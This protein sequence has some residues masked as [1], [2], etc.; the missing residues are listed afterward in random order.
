MPRN[1]TLLLFMLF[2]LVGTG[3]RASS[4]YM[5]PGSA[6][7]VTRDPGAATV[8][9]I[10]PS[11]SAS[12][13]QFTVLDSR[14]RFLGDALAET[15]FPVKVPPGEHIFLVWGENTAAVRANVAPGKFYYIEVAPR[16][17]L[18]SARVQLLAITPRSKSWK[19]LLTW[20]H[21]SE[22]M[23]PIEPAGQ[24]YLQSRQEDTAERIRRA[25]KILTEYD[26]EELEERTIR[27]EDGQ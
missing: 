16:M 18:F 2:A 22:M 5:R 19:D 1:L 14:G 26:A 27:P 24:Y 17:G 13:Q 6:M 8:I 3:C 11:S 21:D 4:D 7:P 15:Y 20:M 10:R 25:Q 23:M 9:F 12:G